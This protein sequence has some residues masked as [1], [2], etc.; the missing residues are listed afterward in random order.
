[1]ADIFWTDSEQARER[2]AGTVVMYD[3]LPVYVYDIENGDNFDD[4]VPRANIQF[5]A[6]K[7]EKRQRKRLD[8]PKFNKFRS[9]PELGWVNSTKYGAILLARKA[10]RTRL[11]GLCQTNVK[12]MFFYNAPEYQIIPYERAWEYLYNTQSFVDMCSNVYPALADVLLNVQ[13]NSALGFSSKFAVYR[14]TLGLRWLYRETERIGIFTN[15]NSLNL[16]EKFKFYREE[17][18]AEP[19]FTLD[20]IQEY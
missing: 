13:E 8:S 9:L 1:M 4:G 6:S 10:A 7:E 18:M 3:N 14:D 2:L 20:N 12:G 15:S 11:H 19:K 16:L 17:I 5:C